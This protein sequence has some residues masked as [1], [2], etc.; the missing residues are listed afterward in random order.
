MQNP[1]S[2]RNLARAILLQG[3]HSTSE[4]CL[5][6]FSDLSLFANGAVTDEDIFIKVFRSLKLLAAL[7]PWP[8]AEVEMSSIEIG[9]GGGEGSAVSWF[10]F[11]VEFRNANG[12]EKVVISAPVPVSKPIDGPLA[13]TFAKYGSG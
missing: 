7:N 13:S 5:T 8:A 11:A 2:P 12:E 3:Y 4:I 9:I 1:D 10:R 6:R